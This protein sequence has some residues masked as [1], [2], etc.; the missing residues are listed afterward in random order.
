MFGKKRIRKP[1]HRGPEDLPF[2]DMDGKE[3]HVGDY[4]ESFRY[5]LGYCRILLTDKGYV[6]E[7]LENGTRINWAR[8]I[9]ASTKY[10]K[11]KKL[12]K[13]PT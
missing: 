8:M 12:D 4:V 2:A 1:G 3:L 9:D 5:A 7:S 11:V 10:Q 13:K 6:Y